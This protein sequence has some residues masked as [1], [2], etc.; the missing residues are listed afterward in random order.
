MNI[1]QILEHLNLCR[2]KLSRDQPG[3]GLTSEDSGVVREPFNDRVG[4]L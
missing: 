2:E 3:W 1:R 4:E